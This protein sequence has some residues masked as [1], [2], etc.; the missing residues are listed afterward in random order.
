MDR[1]HWINL[2]YKLRFWEEEQVH[3]SQI[4]Q[5][6]FRP[7]LYPDKITSAPHGFYTNSEKKIPRTGKTKQKQNIFPLV[8]CLVS[9]KWNLNDNNKMCIF[10]FSQSCKAFK[11]TLKSNL[12]CYT[13]F[14]LL[15]DQRTDRRLRKKS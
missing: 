5:I 3:G 1:Q 6:T 2:A 11:T 15:M 4:N 8:P 14:L 9:P 12:T 7:S 13:L 10:F